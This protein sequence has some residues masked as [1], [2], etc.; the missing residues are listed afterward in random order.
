MMSDS[1][2][3]LRRKIEGARDLRSV[4]STMKAM[5]AAS[6]GQ[7]ERSTLALDDY[8]RAVQLGLSVCFR[9]GTLSPPVS[10]LSPVA[11][12]KIN[13]ENDVI[14]AVLFGSDQGLVG[15]FNEVMADYAIQTLAALPGKIRVWVMGERLHDRLADMSVHMDLQVAGLFTVPLSVKAIT[16][17]VGRILMETLMSSAGPSLTPSLRKGEERPTGRNRNGVRQLYLFYNSSRSGAIY[18][19]AHQ[20]LLPLDDAWRSELAQI[21]WPTNKLPEVMGNGEATLHALIREYLFV[22]LFR[23]CAESLVSENASRLAAMERA[24]KNIDQLSADLRQT[25]H[26]LRQSKIDE[27]LFDVIAGVE[28]LA[29]RIS[30]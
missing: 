22:S 26:R 15:Q 12:E 2:A 7:Y 4:V 28:A 3:S 23:A 20:R 13:R 21:P 14:G 1:I 24:E 8:Y 9:T 19:P 25:F 27:E 5:A 18:A 29:G 10:S 6:I 17:L 16:P 30:S 11:G